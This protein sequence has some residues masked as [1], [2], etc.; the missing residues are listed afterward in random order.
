MFSH[1]LHIK[2]ADHNHDKSGSKSGTTDL[3]ERDHIVLDGKEPSKFIGVIAEAFAKMLNNHL[4]CDEVE[5]MLLVYIIFEPLT[6]NAL[7]TSNV[8]DA[9]LWLH[10][11]PHISLCYFLL[12]VLL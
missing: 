10:H 12:R 4:L 6:R 8:Y 5:C 11:C 2:A 3:S 1:N 7:L 9:I